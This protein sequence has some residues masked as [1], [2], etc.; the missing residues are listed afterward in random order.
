LSFVSKGGM[1]GDLAPEPNGS[2][3]GDGPSIQPYGITVTKFC[4]VTN[5][6][7]GKFL[8]SPSVTPHRAIIGFS[9][10]KF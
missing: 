9:A 10:P 7:K 8:L 4:T 1:F 6:Q 2:S 5:Q 3:P